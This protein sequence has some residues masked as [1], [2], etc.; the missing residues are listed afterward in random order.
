LV[1]VQAADVVAQRCVDAGDAPIE[2]I[3]HGTP[4]RLKLL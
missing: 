1:G 2:G 4:D 3:G